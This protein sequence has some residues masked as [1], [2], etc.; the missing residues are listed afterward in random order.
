MM[1]IRVPDLPT[2]S[3]DCQIIR[4]RWNWTAQTAAAA[5]A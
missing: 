2:F 1:L 3:P 4:L 5:A